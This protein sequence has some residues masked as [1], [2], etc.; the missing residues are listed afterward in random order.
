LTFGTHLPR[1]GTGLLGGIPVEAARLRL[2][3]ADRNLTA[4]WYLFVPTKAN[5]P[6]SA[7]YRDV[8]GGDRAP[9]LT[10]EMY[11]AVRKAEKALTDITI[12]EMKDRFFEARRLRFSDASCMSCH[13]TKK[14]NGIAGMMV[15][16]VSK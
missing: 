10:K 15:Y 14:L 4:A 1:E 12:V 16:M 9:T 7:S 5:R 8:I 13:P 6:F 3:L 2:W 11:D